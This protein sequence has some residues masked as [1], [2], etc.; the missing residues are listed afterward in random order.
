ML[1]PEGIPIGVMHVAAMQEVM[2]GELGG[3]VTVKQAEDMTYWIGEMAVMDGTEYTAANGNVYVL[4]MDAEGMWSAMY[5]KVMVMVD[6]GTQ[7][8]ITLE[9]A[10]DMS[11]WLG[12]EA[13]DVASE[14]MSDNGNTYTLWYTDGVWTARFEPEMMM[15]EGTGLTAMTRE[16]D[17]MYD[18]GDGTLPASG[19][20]D[21]MD[22]GAMYHV[23]AQEDGGLAGARFDAALGHNAT[24]FKSGLAVHPAL[25]ADDP[26]TPEN[27]TRTHLLVTGSSTTGVGM[28]S[29]GDLLGSGTASAAGE[30][31]V[32]STVESIEEVRADV[33]A[34]LALENRPDS[35]TAQALF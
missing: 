9:R 12:S 6:L 4:M 35:V 33:S 8:S 15:I 7:G 20:G 23:W 18:V 16:A 17:D 21:V 3:T 24:R 29:M 10:E 11:W 25:G 2:L 26:D 13:V 1:S 32:D 27:E 30:R 31:F 28:F 14:V 5:Q 34:L 19:M 22:G